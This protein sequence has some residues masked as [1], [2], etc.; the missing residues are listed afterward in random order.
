MKVK[1]AAG[2]QPRSAPAR[3]RTSPRSR[4]AGRPATRPVARPRRGAAHA[5][6]GGPR[7]HLPRLSRGPIGGR[8]LAGLLALAFAGGLLFC[9]NGPWL[10]VSSIAS[11]GTR[12]T[13]ADRLSA[14]LDP[15][16]GE[17]LLSVDAGSL[18]GRLAALPAVASARVETRF[19]DG[20]SVQLVEK[21]PAL[22][23]QTPA[24]RLVV[25][26]DG[27]VFGE[28]ALT[29]TL[30]SELASLPYVTDGRSASRNIIIGDRIPAAEMATALE[31]D[32]IDPA[33]LGSSAKGI[34]VQLTDTC[35]YVLKPRPSGT[36]QAVFG[37][38]GLDVGDADAVKAR[39][40]EQVAAVRTLFAVH[41]ENTVGRVDARNPGKVYWRANGPG[42]SDAC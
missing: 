21:T 6:R 1:R 38:Y 20:V 36:W 37:L 24:V 32:R 23:W 12:Y 10:R 41:R 11:A 9:V 31:L 5:R 39:I 4:D 19:P 17:S 26:A 29:A 30:P 42:G 16:R 15:V 18:A 35:G 34:S 40:A 33:A 8:I 3:S 25:A 27:T 22:T 28:V 14:V 2:A 13:S 7:L